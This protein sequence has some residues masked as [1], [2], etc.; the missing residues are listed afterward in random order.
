[1]LTKHH[2]AWPKNRYTKWWLK[3]WRQLPCNIELLEEAEH[4]E[5]H[6]KESPPALPSQS[7]VMEALKDFNEGTCGCTHHPPRSYELIKPK[8]V[9]NGSGTAGRSAAAQ[10]A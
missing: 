5:R 4:R 10:E 2:K 9:A 3:F 7:E 6:Q 1:M 8:G